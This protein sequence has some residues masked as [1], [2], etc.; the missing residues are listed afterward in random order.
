[1]HSSVVCGVVIDVSCRACFAGTRVVL[2]QVS[3]ES[4]HIYDFIVALHKHA[5]GDYATLAKDTGLSQE[6]IDAYLNY[7]AQFL[8]NLGI[9]NPMYQLHVRH[10]LT[11]YIEL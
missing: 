9:K 6:E 4:E 5:K 2:R 11:S 3:P 7:S 10:T 1:V 8:G